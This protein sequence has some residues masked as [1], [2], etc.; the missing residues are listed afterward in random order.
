VSTSELVI[1]YCATTV[2]NC[3]FVHK[4]AGLKFLHYSICVKCRHWKA[5]SEEY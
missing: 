4:H 1:S 5:C 3:Q 2:S